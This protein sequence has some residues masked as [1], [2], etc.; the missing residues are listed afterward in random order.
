M[1]TE[2]PDGEVVVDDVVVTE[3]ADGE[4]SIVEEVVGGGRGVRRGR[5]IAPTR[6]CVGCRSALPADQLIRIVRL[7]GGALSVDRHGAGRGA[8]LCRDSPGCLDDAV[9]RHGFERAFR[10]SIDAEDLQQ[11][12]DAPG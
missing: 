4:P 3:S 5:G 6:T 9:R 12:H 7:P 2:T 10:A 11:L 8:W 1:V